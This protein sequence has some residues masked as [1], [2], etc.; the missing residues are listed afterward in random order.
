MKTRLLL[1]ISFLLVFQAERLPAQPPLSNLNQT[2]PIGTPLY[3][4]ADQFSKF[5]PLIKNKRVA[6]VANQTSVVG[7]RH[8]ADSLLAAGVKLVKILR[9]NMVSGEKLKPEQAS[10]VA[11]IF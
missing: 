7:N 4:G 6:L 9:L 10:K 2:N 8:L 11:R 5:L 1:F 3:T